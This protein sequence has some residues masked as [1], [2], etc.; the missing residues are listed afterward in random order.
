MW[1]MMVGVAL[2]GGRWDGVDADVTARAT[3]PGT[4][5]QAYAVVAD[6]RG[7]SSLFSDECI[8]DW[9]FGPTPTG[10]GATARLT[11]VPGT[12]HRRLTATYSRLEPGRVI[13]LDHAGR[14]GFV[15]RWT[16]DAVDEGTEVTMTTFLNP[17]AWPFAEW[18]HVNVK[19]DWTVCQE[20]ALKA[21]GARLQ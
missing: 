12:M 8:V 3:V 13:D 1:W 6:L 7:L 5:E 20:E 21:L 14:R 18:Y 2:A 11:Y 17:P 16:F 15:T 19:P 9:A 10:Q 4:P